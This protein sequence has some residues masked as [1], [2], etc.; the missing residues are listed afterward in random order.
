MIN[1]S[2]HHDCKEELNEAELR[3]TPARMAV[4]KLLETTDTPVDVQ[5]IIDYLDKKNIKTDPATA[6]RIVN[7]FL[8]KGIV[9][10]ISFNEGKFRYE[11]SSKADHHHLVCESCGNIEDISDCAIPDLEKDIKKKK[12]FLV[13]RHSLEF[14]GLCKDCQK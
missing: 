13:K 3:A 14:F 1:V 8:A 7:M 4:M 2:I 5:M 11:L 6:F 9:K 12:E 10:Q